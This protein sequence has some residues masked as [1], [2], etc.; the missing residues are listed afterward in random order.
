[1]YK[2]KQK[3]SRSKNKEVKINSHRTLTV[4]NDRTRIKTMESQSQWDFV[5][6][7]KDMQKLGKKYKL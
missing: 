5:P 7:L 1:M 6:K 4:E 3:D 2:D